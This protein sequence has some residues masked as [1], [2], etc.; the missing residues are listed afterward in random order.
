M[1][2][3]Q[4]EVIAERYQIITI[5]GEGGMGSTYAAFDLKKSQSVAIKAISLRE[6][7]DWK[8][9]ELF[10]REAKVLAGIDHP[11]IPDY[12]DYF[13]LDSDEDRRFYLV[14]ELVAGKSLA[15]LVANDWH[16]T[17]TEVKDIAIQLL[18]ILTYLHSRSPAIIHRDIKPQN[19]ILRQDN[20]IYLVDFGAVQDIYRHQGDL[21]KTMVGTFGYMSVEQIQGNAIP[22]SDLYSLGCC[23]LFLLTQKT[24]AE[25]S[26]TSMK[27]D[28]ASQVDVSSSFQVWLE[29]I[30]EPLAENRFASAI[31]A[32]QALQ[33]ETSA[34]VVI[35]DKENLSNTKKSR[36][37]L[38]QYKNSLRYTISL[39]SY[40][41]D[42]NKKPSYL[43]AKVGLTIASLFIVPEI[44]IVGICVWLF[45]LGSFPNQS[46][47]KKIALSAPSV[48]EKYIALEISPQTFC[49]ERTTGIDASGLVKIDRQKGKTADIKWINRLTGDGQRIVIATRQGDTE[50]QYAFGDKHLSQNEAEEIIDQIN[51]FI[52]NTS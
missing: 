49:L 41:P 33:N 35:A 52:K 6:A 23:L 38:S 51:K 43:L 2:H 34:L 8:I 47:S 12:I 11:Y 7:K 15:E 21:D 29:K 46:K 31:E 4:N 16:P 17:E 44:T 25:F 19:I 24:P 13:E 40:Y 30:L 42:Q 20:R 1:L 50:C 37:A 9:L 48:A 22:A 10:E 18:N 3:Q 26:T 5:L 45:Y 32:A 27:L 28:F 39:G 14:Q 36:L